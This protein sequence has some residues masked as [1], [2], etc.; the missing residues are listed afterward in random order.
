MPP[1]K[2]HKHIGVFTILAIIAVFGVTLACVVGVLS[3]VAGRDSLVGTSPTAA[4]S[5]EVSLSGVT[6]LEMQQAVFR[7]LAGL[8]VTVIQGSRADWITFQEFSLDLINLY[9]T[10]LV[11]VG[12]TAQLEAFRQ[13]H[14]HSAFPSSPPT[15]RSE[16]WRSTWLTTLVESVSCGFD[17][18]TLREEAKSRSAAKWDRGLLDGR[19]PPDLQRFLL[20]LDVPDP[21]NYNELINNSNSTS[22]RGTGNS[23]KTKSDYTHLVLRLWRLTER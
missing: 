15:A 1:E 11:D 19:L 16:W 14:L 13:L 12:C 18:R 2:V 8:A 21:Q 23:Q 17:W 10:L 22:S 20:N 3:Y 9:S 5:R 6:T 7:T 4:P